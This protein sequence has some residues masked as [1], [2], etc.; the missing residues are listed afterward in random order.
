MCIT[1]PLYVDKPQTKFA[2]WRDFVGLALAILLYQAILAGMF[3][4]GIFQ[5]FV[6]QHTVSSDEFFNSI[7]LTIV[8]LLCCYAWPIMTWDTVKSTFL[9][10]RNFKD[11][12]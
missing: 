10:A 9:D 4:I 5:L 11:T 7:M 6:E 3:A 12:G 2:A 8:G 1:I